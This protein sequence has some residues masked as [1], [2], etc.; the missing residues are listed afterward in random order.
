ME[1]RIE[2]EQVLRHWQVDSDL[3][4]VRD[5]GSLGKLPQSERDGWLAL[6]TDVAALLQKA[7]DSPT[8][9]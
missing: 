2:A 3:A 9:R 5:E 4:G 8:S 6:W 7:R 1:A